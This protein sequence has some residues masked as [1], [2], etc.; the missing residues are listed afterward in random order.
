MWLSLA[1]ADDEVAAFLTGNCETPHERRCWK[2]AIAAADTAAA[3][4]RQ[5]QSAPDK[6]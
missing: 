5:A 3:D 6:G 2:I 1:I 4:G